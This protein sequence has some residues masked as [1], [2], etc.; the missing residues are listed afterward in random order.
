[1][2]T[3]STSELG[4][5]IYNL[6]E[7]IPTGISGLLVNGFL[8]EQSLQEVENYTGDDIST[9]AVPEKY[10][11][12]IINLSISQVLSQME[13]QG[14]GTKSVKIGELSITKGMHEGTSQSFKQLAYSQLNDLPKKINYYQTWV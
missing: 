14:L 7:N 1:M 3:Y 9:I 6:I 10:Q 2:T 8:P 4:S 5:I 12:S 13:A 11:P